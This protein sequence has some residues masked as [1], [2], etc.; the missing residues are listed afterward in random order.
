MT[1]LSFIGQPQIEIGQHVSASVF[2]FTIYVDTL[3]SIALVLLVIAGLVFWARR[4]G[5]TEGAPTGVQNMLEMAVE[6]VGGLIGDTIGERGYRVAPLLV[7]MFLYIIVAN[8]LGL[9]LLPGIHFIS[10]TS[11]LNSTLALAL[12]TFILAQYY[13]FRN[14]GFI[15]YLKHYFEPI[16]FLAPINVIEELSKPVTL[17][18]RLFGNILAGEVMLLVLAFFLATFLQGVT[19]IVQG[20]VSHVLVGLGAAVL[21]AVDFI[22]SVGWLFYS[23]AI[24]AIQA[25]IFTMLTIAYFGQAMEHHEPG[26]PTVT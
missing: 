6:F 18:F 25:F 16:P 26:K 21:L 13:A 14:R 3:I 15:G 19:Q 7:T 17:S 9:I 1:R 10:P 24:G 2:G 22:F 11:D 4:R 20:T 8:W 12:V 5:I 23:L